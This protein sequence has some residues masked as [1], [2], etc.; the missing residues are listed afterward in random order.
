MSFAE[1]YELIWLHELCIKFGKKANELI[2]IF[3]KGCFFVK[4]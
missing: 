1:K 4:Y 3:A 2:Q